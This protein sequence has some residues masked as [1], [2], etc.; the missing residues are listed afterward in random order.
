LIY[1]RTYHRAYEHDP[2]EPHV[3]LLLQALQ[4][5][6]VP[7]DPLFFQQRTQPTSEKQNRELIR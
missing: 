1:V 3:P 7:N 6:Q 4:V 2:C 5:L